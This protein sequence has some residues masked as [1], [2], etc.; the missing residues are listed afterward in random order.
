MNRSELKKSIDEWDDWKKQVLSSLRPREKKVLIPE[1]SALALIGVRRCGKSYKAIDI[2]QNFSKTLYFNFEDPLFYGTP[3]LKDID[4]LMSVYSEYWQGKP[5]CVIFDE[6]YHI[7]GWERWARKMVD[8]NQFTLIVTGSSAKM[9]SSEIATSLTGRARESVIWPLSFKEFINFKNIKNQDKSQ[10]LGLLLE[11]MQWGGFP[12]VVL[13]T[14]QDEKKEILKQYIT[15]IVL[16]DVI[17]RNNIRNKRALDQIIIYYFTNVSSLH[18]Y[19]AI[20]KAFGIPTQ[21]TADYTQ[22]LNDSYTVFELSR[23]HHNMKVQHRDPKKIYVID[24]GLRNVHN[25]SHQKDWGKL[26][27]NL[28]YLQLRR[29]CNEIYYYNQQGEVDF[30][31]T[32][33]GQPQKAIQVCYSNLDNPKTY[34]REIDSL[35][36]CISILGLAEGTILTLDREETITFNSLLIHM[37]P[38]YKWLLD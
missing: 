22:F 7:K 38:L 16:K 12:D 32:D 14:S 26:A 29:Y 28:V 13:T 11:Y 37:I 35:M 19:N 17:S 34:Q 4:Q 5:E 20:K 33:H 21:T 31:V 15:D 2:S 9:L 1:K 36:R 10:Y 25:A 3:Q 18:S 6:V 30:I 24:T 8:L 27:E 23:Y